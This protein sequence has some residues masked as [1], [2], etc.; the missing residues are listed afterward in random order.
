M[1]MFQPCGQFNQV[2]PLVI[3][4]KC[5]V[6]RL[7]VPSAELEKAGK[8]DQPLVQ[9]RQYMYKELAKHRHT[10]LSTKSCTQSLGQ[11]RRL[12]AWGILVYSYA[13]SSSPVVP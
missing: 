8:T 12:K 5:Q 13:F 10:D 3:V 1:A 7:R 4:Q 2:N 9:M 6:H 11:C